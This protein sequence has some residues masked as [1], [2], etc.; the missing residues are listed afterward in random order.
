MHTMTKLGLAAGIVAAGPAFAGTD[1]DVQELRRELGELR[2]DNAEI[3]AELTELRAEN[4]QNWLT[5]QRAS[6]IRGVVQDVLADAETRMSLQDSGAMAGWN[7]GFY[8]QSAD[9]NFKLKINGQIQF[10]WTLNSAKNQA[11]QWGFE[12]RRTKLGFE[13]HVIDPSWQYKIKY[14]FTNVTE[15]GRLEEAWIQKD[16]GTVADG[17]NGLTVK[18]GAFKAP[19]LRSELVSSSEQLAVDRSVVN[20]YFNQDYSKGIQIG[21]EADS[22]RVGAWYGDGLNA[23]GLGYRNSDTQNW[24]TN[25]TRWAF[26]GRFEY[27]LDGSWGQFKDFSSFR[28]EDFGVLF[29]AAVMGQKFK[30]IASNS[31]NYPS[32]QIFSNSSG[33]LQ[34]GLSGDVTVD[35]GGGSLFASF[36]WQRN[37]SAATA[38][39]PMESAN[40]WGAT[41]QGGYFVTESVELFGRYAYLDY[42]VADSLPGTIKASGSR[43]NGITIGFNWFLAAHA[44]KFTTDWSINFDSFGT[45]ANQLAGIGWRQ[46]AAADDKNQWAMRAQM[47]LLF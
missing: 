27:K 6:E 30:G 18:V 39:G 28:G 42:D 38:A 13:G 8:L 37:N 17:M 26:A 7:K 9:G 36:V 3:K 15:Q 23:I 40:P 31:P 32:T 25:A 43:Y 34:Y 4:G 16:L 20:K 2:A 46:D 22:W 35:F 14:A 11:T 12:N 10:R 5:E 21:Y 24:L 19:W 45:N 47:Q 44:V 33:A 1:G 29:G 41:I